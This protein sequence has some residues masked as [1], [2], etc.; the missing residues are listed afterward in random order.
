MATSSAIERLEMMVKEGRIARLLRG[1]A[2]ESVPH[3]GHTAVKVCLRE[4]V[5]DRIK[6]SVLICGEV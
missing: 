6:V 5:G 3:K 1:Q 2:G 4:G